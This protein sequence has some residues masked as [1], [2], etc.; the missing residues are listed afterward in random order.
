VG[1]AL[2]TYQDIERG[3]LPGADPLGPLNHAGVFSLLLQAQ[4]LLPEA[5]IL[6][7]PSAD[8]AIVLVP[9]LTEYLAT[10]AGSLLRELQRRD[11]G[12]S[13]GYSLGFEEDG[14]YHAPSQESSWTPIVSDRPPRESDR[15][16]D[17]NSPNHGGAGQNVLFAD[18][19]VSWLGEARLGMDGLF[20]NAAGTSAAGQGQGD[21]VIGVSEAVPFPRGR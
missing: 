14:V 10:P 18:G 11:M 9:R 13:Y 3:A 1:V 6:I 15:E 16:A 21:A 12:G 19:H 2:R 20:E 4:G 17:G 8:S 5:K 7:C